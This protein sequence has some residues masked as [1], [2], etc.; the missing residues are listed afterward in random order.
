[1]NTDDTHTS[2][3]APIEHSPSRSGLV[4][5]QSPLP[6]VLPSLTGDLQAS[7]RHRLQLVVYTATLFVSATLLFL[8][9]PMVGKMILPLYGGTPAVWNTCMVFFQAALLAGYAYAHFSV[10]KWGPGR[11]SK[12]HVVLLALPLLCLPIVLRSDAVGVNSPTI[13]LL[14]RLTFGVGLPF[15]LV[16]TTGPL[17]QRWFAGSGHPSAHD[18]YFLYAASNVGSLLALLGYPILVEPWLGVASQSRFWS[19]GYGVLAVMLVGCA[20]FLRSGAPSGALSAKLKEIANPAGSNE[21]G[22]QASQITGRQRLWWIF[23]A[24]LPSSL[25]LGVTSHI[26]TNLAPVPLLWVLPLA[27]YLLTFVLVFAK[28]PPIPQAAMVRTYPLALMALIMLSISGILKTGALGIVVHLSVFF[29][30]A[31]ACHG[32]LARRRPA[33]KH[34]TEFYLLMSVGG[35]LGGMFNAVVAPMAFN[36]LAEYPLILA[37]ACLALPNAKNAEHRG[38][39]RAM[40]CLWP[41]ILSIVADGLNS[42]LSG[43]GVDGDAVSVKLLFGLPLAMCCFLFLGRPLRFALGVTVMY[44]SVGALGGNRNGAQLYEG[45]NFYGVKRVVE[46]ADGQLRMLVHGTTNHGVQYTDPHRSREPLAYY[47]RTGPLGDVF[48]SVCHTDLVRRVGIIGL[49]AGA[50]ASY[51]GPDD[52]HTIYEIDPDVVRLAENP[53]FFTFLDRCRGVYEVVLGDGRL[54][55]QDAPDQ[56]FGLIILDAFSSDAIPTHLLTREAIQLYL[57]KLAPDGLLVMHVSNRYLDIAP[58]VGNLAA[59]AGLTGINR[60]EWTVKTTPETLGKMPS[61]WVA[62]SRNDEALKKLISVDGWELLPTD[63]DQPVWTDQRTSLLKT[64]KWR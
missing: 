34:L 26:T 44:L 2:R 16:S 7:A 64:V 9:Q 6:V 60:K 4:D 37:V 61:H 58:V 23:T 55:I 25:M 49:G 50:I 41:V 48:N 12:A 11:Q 8:V 39:A 28:R 13:D 32:E 17:L 18:P 59:D 21:I 24:F 20:L 15:L 30:A 63:P 45:R 52:Q 35:V 1:M 43:V 36:T 22:R 38:K 54:T 31:M 62:L 57:Q 14:Q 42:L 3:S 53:E 33:A 40:D 27:I 19:I 47:H 10:R 56:G 5:S 46:S 29:I 51:A